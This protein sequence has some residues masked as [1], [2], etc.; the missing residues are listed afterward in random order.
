VQVGP[1][2]G[3]DVKRPRVP[4]GRSWTRV[5][6][7]GLGLLLA[8][9][10]AG[11]GL[12]R[13]EPL[14]PEAV[15]RAIVRAN[16]DRDLAGMARFMA[17]DPDAV[18]YSIAGSKFI[19]WAAVERALVEEFQTV[20]R[21]EMPIHELR[22][23]VRDS[24]AYFAMELDYVRYIGTGPAEQRMLVP[25][26][27]TGVLERRDG[28]W[29]LVAWHESVRTAAGMLQAEPPPARPTSRTSAARNLGGHWRVQET[30][31][32][33]DASLDAD[34]NG[35][36]TWQG[37]RIKTTRLEGG[38][39]EGTWHQPG[40]DREGGFQLVLSDDGTQAQGSWWYTRV[41]SR[42]VPPREWGGPYFWKRTVPGS[43]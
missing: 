38:I 39:W 31:R 23:W 17:K 9:I 11:P 28:Q 5:A 20:S 22:V 32:A 4:R 42:K 41:D 24:F 34:G 26:R 37:G 21:L 15:I 12:A 40:N 14:G 6:G 35:T 7:A 10:I 1:E 19:G 25:L 27:E 16:A 3:P 13:A 36:Y 18:N 8:A 43:R 2:R 30:D 29:I 33:Y